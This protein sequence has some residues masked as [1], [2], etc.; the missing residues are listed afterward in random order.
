MGR[1]ADAFEKART[2]NRAALVIYLCAGDPDLG[3]TEDLVVADAVRPPF[4]VVDAVLLDAPCTGTG[5]LARHPD[6]RW[7]LAPSAIEEMAALQTRMLE[8]AADLVRPGGLLVYSTCTLEPEENEGQVREFLDL[9]GELSAFQNQAAMRDHQRKTIPLPGTTNH[10]VSEH[11]TDQRPAGE[12]AGG[13]RGA[14]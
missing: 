9:R 10:G 4:T 11:E 8:V 13:A 14:T 2:E 6:A 12:A 1:I 5:T 7:R 3:A